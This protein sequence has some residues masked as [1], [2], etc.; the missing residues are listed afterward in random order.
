LVS[1]FLVFS[2]PSEKLAARRLYF[3]GVK[4]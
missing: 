3:A 1:V 2:E 4:F